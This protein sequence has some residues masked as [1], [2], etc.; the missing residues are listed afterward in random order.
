MN[1]NA[2]T[3]LLLATAMLSGCGHPNKPD[4]SIPAGVVITMKV[5]HIGDTLIGEVLQTTT[6]QSNLEKVQSAVS[7]DLIKGNCSLGLPMSWDAKSKRH[8]AT[9]GILGCDGIERVEFP[10]TL[11]ESTTRM[12]GLK[13]VALGDMVLVLITEPARIK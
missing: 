11:V 1:F 4:V 10:A 5:N 2:P 3:L 12:V 9:V 13:G 6:G 8:Y 7:A